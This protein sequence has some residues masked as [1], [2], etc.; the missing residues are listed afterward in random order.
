MVKQLSEKAKTPYGF[1]NCQSC[2]KCIP[3]SDAVKNNEIYKYKITLCEDCVKEYRV[4][5]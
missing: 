1:N 3:T 5:S 2:S 4:V